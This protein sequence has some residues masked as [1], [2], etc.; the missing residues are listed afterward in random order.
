M[1]R[2]KISLGFTIQ[3]KPY[4]SIRVDASVSSDLVEDETVE[5]GLDR[6][7]KNVESYLEEQVAEIKQNMQKIMS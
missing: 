3:P 1:D 2:V 6:V 7:R 5:Q 4:E